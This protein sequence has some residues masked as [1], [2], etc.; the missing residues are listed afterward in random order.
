MGAQTKS[1]RN[2][3]WFPPSPISTQPNTSVF[4][5]DETPGHNSGT[6]D[7]DGGF[8]DMDDGFPNHWNNLR[9]SQAR[10]DHWVK[11]LG[12]SPSDRSTNDTD[13]EDHSKVVNGGRYPGAS[14]GVSS[15]PHNGHITHNGNAFITKG[16]RQNWAS[17]QIAK[18]PE[19]IKGVEEGQTGQ[20][21][22]DNM[23]SSDIVTEGRGTRRRFGLL[24]MTNHIGLT[25][26]H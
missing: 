17:M 9:S 10:R 3:S 24:R 22:M 7:S 6:D 4:P 21:Y 1:Y 15:E 16:E 26:L 14:C 11:S 2:N 18:S 12:R 13:D 5:G 23:G 19:K 20:L 25:C 8:D